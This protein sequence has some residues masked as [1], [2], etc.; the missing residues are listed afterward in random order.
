[1]GNACLVN[2]GL[3]KQQLPDFEEQ[4]FSI[5][6]PGIQVVLGEIECCMLENR[7]GFLSGI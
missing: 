3:I 2:A 7:D 1:M 4:M 6:R 5:S